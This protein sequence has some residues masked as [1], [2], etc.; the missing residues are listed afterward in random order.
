[1]FTIIKMFMSITLL[2]SALLSELHDAQLS[3]TASL[4]V[5]LFNQFPAKDK[6]ASAEDNNSSLL[7]VNAETRINH[8]DTCPLLAREAGPYIHYAWRHDL[9]Q[10]FRDV[11]LNQLGESF[12]SLFSRSHST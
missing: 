5:H 2:H 10:I 12:Q 7:Y 6:T 3:E 9:G 4:R 8:V 11:A 1:M